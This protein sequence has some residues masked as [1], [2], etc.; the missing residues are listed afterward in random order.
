MRGMRRHARYA[1][2]STL[3]PMNEILKTGRANEH[4]TTRNI[5]TL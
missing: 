1:P 3:S 2:K 4:I 5:R